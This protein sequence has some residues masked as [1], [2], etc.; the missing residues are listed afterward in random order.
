MFHLLRRIA[1]KYRVTLLSFLEDEQER[2]HLPELESYCETVI[3]MPRTPPVRWQPFAYE[4]F[5]EFL[6][7]EMQDA[8]RRCLESRKYDLLHFE[9]TQMAEYADRTL[10]IPSLLTKHEVDFAAWRRRAQVETHPLRKLRWFYNYLQVLDREVSLSRKVD[11][12]ICVTEPDRMELLR[13]CTEAPV[14]VVNTGV[15]LEY[16]KPG[17]EA[18]RSNRMIFVGAFQHEPNIDAMTY[19]CR[20]VLPRIRK[21][22]AEAELIIVGSNPPDTVRALE[23]IHGVQV[24]G[25]VPDIRPF[26]QEAAV[27]VVPLRLGV[28]IRG[29]ILEAWAMALPVVA[30]SV[31]GA[32]LRHTHGENLLI[33]DSAGE[34]ANCTL[35]LLKDPALQT[36]MG[37]A[38]RRTAEEFYGWDALAAQLDIIYRK[39]LTPGAG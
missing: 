36:S 34:F 38:G 24:T 37:A 28:G 9:Y 18:K 27:Y 3:A 7:P 30:T 13:Y 10:G 21:E 8:L 19:F 5:K 2:K 35:R 14:H 26:M 22:M 25:A 23:K 4:P 6:T 32:G 39:F 29:K 15:D 16:F 1:K 20:Q 12:A 31:A 17:A 11:A 33:A